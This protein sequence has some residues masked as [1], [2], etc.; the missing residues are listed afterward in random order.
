MSQ[1]RVS[2]YAAGNHFA[3]NWGGVNVLCLHDKPQSGCTS[4]LVPNYIYGA[5]YGFVN[6]P[7][8]AANNGGHSLQ[9]HDVQCIVCHSTMRSNQIMIPGRQQCPVGWTHEYTGYIVTTYVGGHTVKSDFICMDKAPDVRVGG[10]DKTN[11]LVF[12]VILTHCGSLPCPRY[13]HSVPLTCV[14]CTK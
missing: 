9:N 11:G 7:F 14:V 4:A 13:I 3:N 12:Q 10:S 5:E 2:G 1:C 8:S 6:A